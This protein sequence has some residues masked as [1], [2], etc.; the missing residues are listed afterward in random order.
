MATPNET[1]ITFHGL[2]EPARDASAAERAVWVPVQ[3]LEALIEAAPPHGL[4]FSF[5][6]GNASDI[7][8]ALPVLQQRGLTARFFILAGRLGRPGYLSA[9]DVARLHEA[10][11]QIG[12]HGLHHRDWRT[13]DDE[14]L[15][16]ETIEARV[17]LSDLI[18][19][20]VT[21]V[22][23]P[24]GSYDRR[25]LRFVREAGYERVFTSDGG[26]GPVG[27][28]VMGRASIGKDIPLEHWLRL[29][30]SAGTERPGALLRAKRTLKRMR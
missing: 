17:T 14:E 23:P 20:P 24:F 22:A 2:G 6:D 21:D 8:L 25:V 1:I 11:M 7:E 16:A 9:E 19:A 5:D 13:L 26:P 12:S 18:G 29:A 3:W 4:G 28:A 27:S 15:A 30:R 10:G